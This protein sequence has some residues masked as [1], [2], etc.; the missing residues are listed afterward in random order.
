MFVQFSDTVDPGEQPIW[1]IDT[2]SAT[3]VQ[4]ERCVGCGLRGWGWND[5]GSSSTPQDRLGAL[6]RFATDGRH[7]IRIQTREDG[8]A[9]DQI[10]LSSER[11]ANTPPGAGR[12]DAT[13]LSEGTAG[14][15]CGAGEVVLHA[16]EASRAGA[17][18]RIADATAASGARLTHPDAHVA[19]RSAPLAAPTNYFELTFT[20]Q[21]NVDYRLWIRGTAAANHWSNDSAWVQFS[22]SIS[23]SGAATW[24][25][26]TRSAATYVLENCTNCPISGWGWNDNEYGGTALGVPVRFANSGTHRIRIQTREDGLS[27]DQIV[28]SAARYLS[29]AP[30]PVRDDATFLESCVR[31]AR[32]SRRHGSRRTLARSTQREGRAG[33]LSRVFDVPTGRWTGLAYPRHERDRGGRR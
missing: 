25:I 32:P 29:S 31:P 8:L 9:L 22:D 30:G 19:R 13:L 23:A 20:A 33:L 26:G 24:G 21:A 17:W 27:I 5:N 4:I 28:L 3:A 7:T 18:Q 6:V 12:D 14:G 1:R 16:A 2:T 10:V 11:Y 15:T